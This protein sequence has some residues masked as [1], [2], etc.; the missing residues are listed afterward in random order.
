MQP[1]VAR[2]A[3]RTAIGLGGSAG[4]R[5][6]GH[7]PSHRAAVA[8]AQIAVEEGGAL[9]VERLVDGRLV[10]SATVAEVAELEADGATAACLVVDADR[11]LRWEEVVGPAVLDQQ[12]RRR[13]G[14]AVGLMVG[15]DLGQPFFGK[16]AGWLSGVDERE[17]A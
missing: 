5:V 3:V 9:F 15:V 17:V 8:A 1:A 11:L 16:R 14:Q 4:L 2:R 13:A 12:R 6:S 7:G 10:R